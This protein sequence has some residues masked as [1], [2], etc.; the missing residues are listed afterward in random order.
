[1][2]KISSLFE[3]VDMGVLAC[4]ICPEMIFLGPG[5]TLGSPYLIIVA[6]IQMKLV[7]TQAY[8]GKVLLQSILAP[9]DFSL[10]S[11]SLLKMSKKYWSGQFDNFS[12]PPWA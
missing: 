5:P 8:L 10:S 3:I 1:M 7:S 6:Q 11:Y 9:L 4:K 2:C 12:T